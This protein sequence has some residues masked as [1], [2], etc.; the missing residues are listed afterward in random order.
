MFQYAAISRTSE[1]RRPQTAEAARYNVPSL[2][3]QFSERSTSAHPHKTA[4]TVHTK[5]TI[6][7]IFLPEDCFL[8]F[9]NTPSPFL[10]LQGSPLPGGLLPRRSAQPL[11]GRQVLH[12]SDVGGDVHS[13]HPGIGVEDFE[14]KSKIVSSQSSLRKW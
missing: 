7:Q 6:K 11:L 9:I 10:Q 14:R 8:G 13:V 4:P 12:D 1:G 2:R 3:R 5:A